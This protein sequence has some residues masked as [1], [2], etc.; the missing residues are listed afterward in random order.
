[1]GHR[2]APSGA[3]FCR[4]DPLC[5]GALGLLWFALFVL[6]YDALPLQ[7]WDE[8][9]NAANAYGLAASGHWLVPPYDG[10]PD[11][12][13]TKP[14][15]LVWSISALM[16]LGAPLLLTIR[17]PSMLAALATV[18]VVWGVCRY[19]LH[20]GV[21]AA[22]AGFL[23]LSSHLYVGLHVARTGDFDVLLSLFTLCYVVTFWFAIER[24]GR[25]RIG[26]F[27]VSAALL[28][29]AVMTKGVA[30]G[31]ALVG[32]LVF[33]LL[34]GGLL[35]LLRDVRV[36]LLGLLVLLLCLGYYFSR[37]LYDPG[38]LQGVWL[39]ELGGRFAV[40]HDQHAQGLQFYPVVLA[41]SFEPGFIL[42]PLAALPLCG[43]DARRRSL[44]MLCLLSVAG[45]LA[46]L[47]TA[48][49]KLFWYA[50][51][52]VPLLAIAVAFGASDVLRWIGNCRAARS[53]R[54]SACALA[55]VLV[56]FLLFGTFGALYQNQ[57]LEIEASR[58]AGQGQ[59]WYGPFFDELRSVQAATDV[60]VLDNGIPNT[61][62]LDHYN[63]ML[64]LYAELAGQHG[65]A[66]RIATFG[67]PIP[68][69]KL[70]ATCDPTLN[71]LLRQRPA[72]TLLHES[73]WCVF[74]QMGQESASHAQ[75][76]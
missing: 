30:G 73:K 43:A 65:L 8:S 31:F 54:A 20:D 26:W 50:A 38:Y 18:G 36:W 27:A 21:A 39:N 10:Q 44:V 68:L 66:V 59:L 29:L 49:T 55:V 76:K 69:G 14:P 75:I 45:I 28:V 37:E 12:W 41:K 5:L 2:H 72:F 63:P 33:A 7:A 23:L 53:R 15:L 1:M 24:G 46:V 61:G 17:L 48:Q 16:R 11:H 6:R 58:T 40:T 9:R 64:K 52:L 34:H 4:W 19:A 60:L 51:P 56:L 42:L 62:G 57:W 25:M 32:L 70:V 22:I 71:L 35:L 3:L 67:A 74:G 13:N 47:T